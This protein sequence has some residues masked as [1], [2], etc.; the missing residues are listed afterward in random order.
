VNESAKPAPSANGEPGADGIT[1]ALPGGAPE[2]PPAAPPLTP[3]GWL[4]Q[5]GPYLAVL[6]VL[7][8]LLYYYTGLEGVYKAVLVVFGLGFVIFI[9]EL[10][11]FATAKWCDVHVKTFSIGFGP[12]LPG[13]SWQRGETTYKIAILP[14]GGYVQMVGE[15]SDGDEEEDDPR[16][17]K[18]KT[19][20]QRMLIIS[21]G[22]IMNIILGAICFIVV[23]QL[24]GVP[25]SPAAISRI[26]PGSPAWQ[27]GVHTGSWITKLGDLSD[28]SFAE[29]K[30]EV[31]LSPAA[32]VYRN[33]FWGSILLLLVGLA[34]VA[35][36]LLVAKGVFRGD[37]WGYA[38]LAGLLACIGVLLIVLSVSGFRDFGPKLAPSIPFTFVRMVDGKEIKQEIDLNPKPRDANTNMPAIGVL[39]QASGIKLVK[40]SPNGLRDVPA[41]RDSAAAAARV[42]DLEPGDRV[43]KATNPSDKDGALTDVAGF[44]ELC[45][46]MRRLAG[47]PM[48][49]VVRR[50]ETGLPEEIKVPAQGFEF[51]D[52]IY[53][54]TDPQ[55]P[56]EPFQLKPLDPA[57]PQLV[58]ET[59]NEDRCPFDLQRRMQALAAK[60][61]V[62][63][64]KR[65]PDFKK[66]NIL[67]PPAYHM[68][69]PLRMKMGK[70]AAIRDHARAVDK[71]KPGDVITQVGVVAAGATEPRKEDVLTDFDP[72]KL[73]YLLQ[74]AVKSKTGSSEV[75]LKVLRPRDA[76]NREAVVESEWIVLPWDEEWSLNDE[77]PVMRFSPMS[78]PELGIA[79]YVD[80]TVQ[81]V[82]D[83]ER[84]GGIEPG[85][86]IEQIRFR[87]LTKKAGEEWS[88]PSEMN[89][90]RD[91]ENVYDEWAYFFFVWMQSLEYP[92]VE[93]TVSRR[94][95]Q[96]DKPVRLVLTE[97]KGWPLADRGLYFVPV[98]KLL[99]SDGL[100]Q[101]LKFGWNDT[102]TSI[103]QIYLTLARLISRDV[104][105]KM[106]GGPIEIA[107]QS[108]AAAED[109]W[110][111][112]LFLGLISVNLAVVNFLPIPILDGGHMVFLIYEKLRG[113]PP[114]EG[115]RAAATWLGLLIILALM[116]FVFYLDIKRRFFGG[117]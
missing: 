113:K 100:G 93:L 3:V 34:A 23:Y 8:G 26:D 57:P 18:N 109:P 82:T 27:K 53:A 45:R 12:A 95:K 66:V 61:L 104:S 37:S 106:L 56:D 48:T 54:T 63:Q 115:V 11:H 94:Q 33:A 25:R 55:T 2:P 20:G 89:S 19:V 107:A 76:G 65:G 5:N 62:L 30:L 14:L 24:N 50:K 116:V 112:T 1:A 99:K 35:T 32:K 77:T 96:L 81:A 71:V 70:V 59:A 43:L 46:R 41:T 108:F 87:K 101:A 97:D 39:G 103:K 13:C 75:A 10:G 90:N 16:S 6:L 110:M 49:I 36:S 85:D 73:P 80:S 42:L 86:V 83:E 15:G 51:E 52:A 74:T 38:V 91:G 88:D 58:G 68:T 60:P 92:D 44:G 114:S 67:V 47:E 31:A 98:M 72:V 40:K 29:M 22:V 17:F 64:V 79:Y 84:A 9:H 117:S 105:P 69:L 28:P 78:I 21:A 7:V 4:A 102:V 111:L